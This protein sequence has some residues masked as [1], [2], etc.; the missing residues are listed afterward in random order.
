MSQKT[1]LMRFDLLLPPAAIE[2][3]KTEAAIRGISPRV[4]GRMLVV[5]KIKETIGLAP[6]DVLPDVNPAQVGCHTTAPS[7]GHEG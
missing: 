1:N 3:I 5:E 7:G 2:V 4:M 6:D